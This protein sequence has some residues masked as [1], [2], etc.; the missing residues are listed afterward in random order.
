VTSAAPPPSTKERFERAL[1]DARVEDVAL[2]LFVSG[3]TARSVRAVAD[4]RRLAEDH[5]GPRCRLEVVD[6][7]QQPERA[8]EEQVVAV[9]MLVK[10]RPPPSSKLVGSLS[11]ARRVLGALRLPGQ[12]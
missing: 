10:E 8:V 1:A 2:T 5:L 11:D 9:P 7:P 3:M 12:P 6:I 4:L